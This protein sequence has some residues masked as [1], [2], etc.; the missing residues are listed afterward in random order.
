MNIEKFSNAVVKSNLINTY[1]ATAFFAILI[2]FVL[3][4][5][6]YTPLEMIVTTIFVTI[7][8]KGIANLMFS[9][10]VMLYKN[11]TD[12]QNQVFDEVSTRIDGLMNE[13]SLQETQLKS[14]VK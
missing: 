8:F 9:Y 6:L 11:N 12:T 10:V 7:T 14:M 4:A 5:N 1:V 3:N 2:Y 13:L